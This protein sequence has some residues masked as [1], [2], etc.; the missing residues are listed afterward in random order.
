MQSIAEALAIEERKT[1]NVHC[2]R[3]G[4][5]RIAVKRVRPAAMRELGMRG[6]VFCDEHAQELY[7]AG[8]AKGKDWE[9][10]GYRNAG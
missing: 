8:K 1:R 5:D 10:T 4:C 2:D 6:N 9:V 3:M 7:K